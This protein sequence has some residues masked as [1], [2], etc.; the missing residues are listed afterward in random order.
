M[1]SIILSVLLIAFIVPLTAQGIFNLYLTLY[2]W[3][4]PERIKNARAPEKTYLPIVGF[5]VLLPVYHEEE[6]IGETL[7]KLSLANYPKQLI[8]LLVIVRDHDTDTIAAAKQSIKDNNITNAK[9]LIYSGDTPGKPP[10]LNAGLQA[11][12]KKIVTI[13]DAEDDVSPDLFGAVN[14][15][16]VR[17]QPDV[18]Q[19]GVQLMDYNGRWYSLLNV[20]EYFFWFRSNMH[21]YARIGVMPLGG[22]TVFFKRRQVNKIGGWDETLLTEDA[23][24]GI[25]LSVAGKKTQVMYDPRLVTKEE[26]P[27]STEQFIK[28]RTRWVQGF[29]QLVKKGE[30]RKLTNKKQFALIMY[31]LGAPVFQAL[32]VVLTPLLI[33]MGIFVDVPAYIS[34]LSYAPLA[35]LVCLLG[36]MLVGLNEFSREQK[37]H[38]KWYWY[39]YLLLS[40]PIYQLLLGISSARAT[41]RHLQGASDWEKT[42]HTGGHRAAPAPASLQTAKEPVT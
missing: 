22:N 20:L 9:V 11:A 35:I 40:F 42:K 33:I 27:P 38:I 12:R 23:D 5:S 10:Q 21:F 31:V 4:S 28:Q 37:L 41:R 19:C 18:V 36:A 16:Y 32:I 34:L 8:E 26:T 7:R 30:W 29:L 15:I 2:G 14:T 6:V 39:V 24:I 13:F 3:E 1:L 25:R 17:D